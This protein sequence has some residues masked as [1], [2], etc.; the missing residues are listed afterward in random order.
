M[1][2]YET[3]YLKLVN[4]EDVIGKVNIGSSDTDPLVEILKPVKVIHLINED[5]IYT[6]RMVDWGI[7]SQIDR[8]HI[9]KDHIITGTNISRDLTNVY[10][11]YIIDRENVARFRRD[12]EN[13]PIS[14][15]E[16]VAYANNEVTLH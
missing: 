8:C 7:G 12:R 6:P 5:G 3:K 2:S 16:L 1:Q 13:N 9:R 14:D 4:G 10:N 11:N 15:E